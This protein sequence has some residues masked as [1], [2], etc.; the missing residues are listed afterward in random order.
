MRNRLF[1][2]VL[3]VSL[4]AT[5][6]FA[7]SAAAADA[8]LHVEQESYVDGDVAVNTEGS[9][10]EYRVRGDRVL[11]TP[12]NFDIEDVQTVGVEEDEGSLTYN[13]GLGVYEFTATNNGTYHVFWEVTEERQQG[14]E[15]TVTT[16]RYEAVISVEQTDMQ[17]LPASRFSELQ[18]NAENW[19][20]WKG[21]VREISG[22]NADIEVETQL[23]ATMLDIRRNPLDALTGRFWRLGVVIFGTFAGIM[24]ALLF[25]LYNW[26]DKRQLRKELNEKKALLPDRGELESKLA[27]LDHKDD[28]QSMV[29]TRPDAWYDDPHI[30]QAA[31]EAHG[32]DMLTHFSAFEEMLSGIGALKDRLQAMAHAGYRARI[33]RDDDGEIADVVLLDPDETDVAAD[34]GDIVALGDMEADAFDA[35]RGA[36]DI[37]DPTLQNFAYHECDTDRSELRDDSDVPDSLDAMLEQMDAEIERFGGDKETYGEYL[38]AM[39]EDVIRHPST[40]SDGVPKGQ[41]WMMEQWYRVGIEARDIFG[42]PVDFQVDI[43][44]DLLSAHDPVE[45]AQRIAKQDRNGED[46]FDLRGDE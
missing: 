16:E 46:P 28:L 10:P 27:E 4:V 33:Q 15:T 42:I 17:V 1:L 13:D 20:E 37:H 8:T 11:I 14:N 45:D 19:E 3:L 6:L 21:T 38:E 30:G 5:P 9:A 18:T 2:A 32:E 44:Q 39:L 41:R 23:A 31:V 29:T 36:V 25:G 22:P 24:W 12:Q 35:L 40:D 26:A 34:G 7:G 43:V